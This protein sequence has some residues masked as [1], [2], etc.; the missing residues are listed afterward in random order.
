[1]WLIINFAGLFT[2]TPLLSYAEAGLID[3]C[4]KTHLLIFDPQCCQQGATTNAYLEPMMNNKK[5][6]SNKIAL[7]R[8]KVKKCSC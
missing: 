3:P 5:N 6:D 8:P 1:M 7:K 2:L 4:G